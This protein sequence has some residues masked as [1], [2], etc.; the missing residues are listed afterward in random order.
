MGVLWVERFS[1]FW[2]FWLAGIIW[3]LRVVWLSV[4]FRLWKSWV[5]RVSGVERLSV[6]WT[7]GSHSVIG[8]GRVVRLSVIW[9]FFLFRVIR[10]SRVIGLLLVIRRDDSRWIVF[11]W[12][13]LVSRNQGDIVSWLSWRSWLVWF[14]WISRHWFKISS[15]GFW[16]PSW[17]SR[18]SWVSWVSWVVWLSWTVWLAVRWIHWLWSWVDLREV[19]HAVSVARLWGAISAF[20]VEALATEALSAKCLSGLVSVAIL[21]EL[22]AEAHWADWCSQAFGLVGSTARDT[23]LQ[24]GIGL[25]ALAFFVALDALELS[26][27]S[28]FAHHARAALL[29]LRREGRREHWRELV[30]GALLVADHAV[31]FFGAS[32]ALSVDA[33]LALAC[34]ADLASCGSGDFGADTAVSFFARILGRVLEQ[35]VFAFADDLSGGHDLSAFLAGAVNADLALSVLASLA[36]LSDSD[37][38]ISVQDLSLDTVLAVS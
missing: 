11:S 32:G 28:E 3:S 30:A 22:L 24:S 15:L 17:F 6:V 27:G 38:R 33:H 25:A 5:V 29:A 13:W 8:L 36:G 10:V 9:A 37:G 34:L 2:A 26:S 16:L 1:V 35:R 4:G 7:L 12:F 18:M 23:F 19:F 31:S 20:L 14:F 21:A